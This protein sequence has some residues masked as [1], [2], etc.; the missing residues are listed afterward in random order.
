MI[1]LM[2]LI[3]YL[4]LSTALVGLMLGLSSCY[5]PNE[6]TPAQRW[7]RSAPEHL[8]LSYE[9]LKKELEKIAVE[10]LTTAVQRRGYLIWEQG[11]HEQPVLLESS[12]WDFKFDVFGAGT[13]PAEVIGV[14]TDEKHQLLPRDLLRY[15]LL[16]LREGQWDKD[17]LLEPDTA[18]DTWYAKEAAWFTGTVKFDDAP[19]Y[20][21]GS[22]DTYWLILLP[23]DEIAFVAVAGNEPLAEPKKYA[24]ALASAMHVMR[25]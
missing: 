19:Y 21:I 22:A 11:Q 5:D 20:A 7:V 2:N 23:A 1:S 3:K 15:G 14:E 25:K 24:D 16:L 17:T 8:A 18:L 4:T 10:E 12:A 13:E 9:K 6:V